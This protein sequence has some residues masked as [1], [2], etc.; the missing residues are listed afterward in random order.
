MIITPAHQAQLAFLKHFQLPL[1]YRALVA[2]YA[3][4]VN[5]VVFF[6]VNEEICRSIKI[7]TCRPA[8]LI[9]CE[10]GQKL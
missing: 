10:N 4:R 3:A 7:K 8:F 2:C 5:N 9:G 1:E 6:F